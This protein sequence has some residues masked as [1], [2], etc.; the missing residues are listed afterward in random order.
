VKVVLLSISDF[1]IFN[2]K[3]LT[4]NCQLPC[5]LSLIQMGYQ[6]GAKTLK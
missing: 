5:V 4:A 1:S 6:K 3:L 2:L